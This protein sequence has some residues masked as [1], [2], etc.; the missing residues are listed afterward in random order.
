[1]KER[2]EVVVIGAGIVGCAAAHYLTLAGV[3]DVVVVDQG[4]IG[5]TGGSSFH[6]PGLCFQTNGSK[7]SCTLAQWSADLFRQPDP[8]G[9][10]TWGGGGPL[11]GAPTP[12]R[13][14]GGKARPPFAPPRGSPSPGSPPPQTVG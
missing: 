3:R 2:A 5:D 13:L 12:P 10:R 4:P 11:G 9:P 14:P 6:A 1:M 7:L 8:P